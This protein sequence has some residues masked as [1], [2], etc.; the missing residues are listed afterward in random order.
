MDGLKAAEQ[1]RRGEFSQ[2]TTKRA[3][4]AFP[5]RQ[6]VE[7][8]PAVSDL[9]ERASGNI[10]VA[11]AKSFKEIESL[12]SVWQLMQSEQP[13][14]TPNAD[15]DRYTSVVESTDGK[16]KP[17][18]M[19]FKQDNRPVAMVI[20]RT[21]DH[22]LSLKLGYQGLLHPRLKCLNVVYG[23]IL[24]RVEGGLCSVVVDE[25]ARQLR[26]REF[27]VVCFNYLAVNTDIYQAVRRVPGFF[28]RGHFPRTAEH[29][30]MAVPE[31]IDKF[32]Q[33]RSGRHRRN[34]RRS[35]K[36]FENKYPAENNFVKY[37]CEGDVDDFV[38]AAAGISSKTYQHAL[39]AGIINDEQTRRRIRTAAA[40]GWFAGNI[41]LAGDKPCA[42]QL[43]LRYGSV[44]YM[45]N[46][47][48][49][50]EFHSYKTGTVL[51]LKVLES[52]CEDPAI[53]KIDFYFGDAEYKKC[54]GTEHWQEACVYIFAPRMYPMAVNALRLSVA[55]VNNGLARVV[56]KTGG[57]DLVKRKW[58]DLLKCPSGTSR[59]EAKSGVT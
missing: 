6:S 12:R 55:G 43:G 33:I 35:I 24:G 54:Y 36:K 30:R 34:L 3:I 5:G 42:F 9:K 17:Y 44:Y 27:D 53:S 45:V 10:T 22:L 19:L 26:S 8:R 11:I 58:R 14:P 51:F 40:H 25:L 37:T 39:G 1:P 59:A 15:I 41:L 4:E 38:R 2:S 50:P 18:V 20:A 32:Y 21:E 46:I 28:T 31:T 47:G 13:S 48:Y 23:G 16:V 7:P 49:D 29:W 52:L 56:Q 57:A